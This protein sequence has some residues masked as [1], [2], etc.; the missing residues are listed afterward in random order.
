M[1]NDYQYNI[2]STIAPDLGHEQSLGIKLEQM[3]VTYQSYSH[4]GR[5][6]V[7]FRTLEQICAAP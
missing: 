7:A 3:C 5:L 6:A 1:T 4:F 2:V